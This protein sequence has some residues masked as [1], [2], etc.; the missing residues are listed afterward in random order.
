M[1]NYQIPYFFVFLLLHAATQ[2]QTLPDAGSVRQQLE[3]Q[4]NLTLPAQVAP[5]TQV[6]PPEIK[7]LQ[8]VSIDVK[9]WRFAGNT[10]RSN[11]QLTA[12]LAD[13]LGQKLDFAGLQRATDTVAAAYRADG[14]VVRAYLPEQDVSEGVITLQVVEAR[15][16]G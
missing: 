3:P 11:E 13:F 16:A 4:P 9:A 15:F 6:A 5:R 12:V 7:P 2:A 8:G 10:L 1:K 14:W